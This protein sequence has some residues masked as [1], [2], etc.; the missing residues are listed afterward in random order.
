VDKNASQQQHLLLLLLQLMLGPQKG[1]EDNWSREFL[2]KVS[3]PDR[4]LT[5]PE[6]VKITNQ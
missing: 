6:H 4:Q 2:Q 1:L 5:L 3:L